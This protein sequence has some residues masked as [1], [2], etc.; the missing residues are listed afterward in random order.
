MQ[1]TNGFDWAGWYYIGRVM[2]YMT[3][4]EFWGATLLQLTTL[5]DQHDRFNKSEDDKGADLF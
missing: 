5:C 4:R 3:E 1:D 2:F